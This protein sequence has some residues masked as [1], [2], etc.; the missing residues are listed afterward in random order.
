MNATLPLVRSPVPGTVWLAAGALSVLAVLQ[1]AMGVTGAP[2]ML[3]AA[4]L[5]M[6]LV[7]GLLTRQRWAHAITLTMCVLSLIVL[8]VQGEPGLALLVTAINAVV[9]LPLLVARGWFWNRESPPAW[10]V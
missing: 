6:L 10:L 9:W 2:A 8:L 3:L 4:V 1:I 5:G 7:W